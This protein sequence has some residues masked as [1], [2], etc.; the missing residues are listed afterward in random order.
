MPFRNA[1]ALHLSN[2]K[3]HGHFREMHS[4][5][6]EMHSHFPQMHGH[7]PSKRT[8]ICGK[9]TVICEKCTVIR[10]AHCGKCTVICEKCTVFSRGFATCFCVLPHS[11][12]NGISV[13]DTCTVSTMPAHEFP[14]CSPP[15][16]S[17]LCRGSYPGANRSPRAPER[18][19]QM[20]SV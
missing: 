8:V 3:M 12:L 17:M 2:L 11:F 13:Y 10:F 19:E 14:M 4:H 15:M 9:R 16:S 20:R 1:C 18:L 5:F 7:F 6:R